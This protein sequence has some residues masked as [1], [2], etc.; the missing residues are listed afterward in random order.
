MCRVLLGITPNSKIYELSTPNLF[1]FDKFPAL[2][3]LAQVGSFK[4]AV[5]K[6]KSQFQNF[7]VLNSAVLKVSLY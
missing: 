2:K 7:A 5:S 4:I 1:I 6:P 3:Q